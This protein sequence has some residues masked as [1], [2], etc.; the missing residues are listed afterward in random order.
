MLNLHWAPLDK[1]R[2]LPLP[3]VTRMVIDLL[4]R[5]L[6]APPTSDQQA[7]IPLVTYQR[8]RYITELH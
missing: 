2:D 5:R 6:D 7:P 3:H 8:G 1:A 4:E